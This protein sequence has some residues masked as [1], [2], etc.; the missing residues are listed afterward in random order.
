MANVRVP[1]ALEG[2]TGG[3]KQIEV[4]GKTLADIVN[5]LETS[6]PGFKERLLDESGELRRFI[7]VYV[8]E[9]DVRFLDGLQT[10]I[11]DRSE[12]SIIPAVA[13]GI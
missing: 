1:S 7:N 9:E 11:S 6:F 10:E 5:G 12:V 2:L 13:G 3:K 8:D 4:E